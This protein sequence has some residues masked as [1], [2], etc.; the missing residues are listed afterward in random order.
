MIPLNVVRPIEGMTI[1]KDKLEVGKE[2]RHAV[3]APSSADRGSW[4]GWTP[5]SFLSNRAEVDRFGY[6]IQVVRDV[7]GDRVM[8]WLK[9]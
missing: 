9:G 6:N 8:A 3:A 1:V 7:K 4:P 5:V 2:L